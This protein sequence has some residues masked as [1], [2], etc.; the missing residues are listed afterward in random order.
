M[1]QEYTWHTF[2]AFVTVSLVLIG[3]VTTRIAGEESSDKLFWIVGFS[4]L[5]IMFA[6]YTFMVFRGRNEPYLWRKGD[7][8]DYFGDLK[9]L[10]YWG[11]GRKPPETESESRARPFFG[12]N[13]L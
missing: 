7:D 13:G 11:E 2:L 1:F 4:V 8:W 9:R 5:F 10:Q 12:T 6:S 3:A